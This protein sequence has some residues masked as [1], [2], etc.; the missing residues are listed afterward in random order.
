MIFELHTP[1]HPPLKKLS[2]F[3]IITMQTWTERYAWPMTNM[4]EN[5]VIPSH[6]L[7]MIGNDRVFSC[8]LGKRH[9]PLQLANLCKF[10]AFVQLYKFHK[11][12]ICIL[13]LHLN[14]VFFYYIIYFAIIS[15]YLCIKHSIYIFYISNFEG[16]DLF[17]NFRS[18]LGRNDTILHCITDQ[19][20]LEKNPWMRL[21]M[22]L[23]PR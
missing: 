4:Q 15:L 12:H 14:Q 7:K 13:N 5:M 22:V 21:K 10:C 3:D 9:S 23:F 2:K 16:Q 19:N 20:C 11:L 8:T 17:G 18:N 1:L 6:R